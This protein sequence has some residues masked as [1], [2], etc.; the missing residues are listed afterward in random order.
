MIMEMCAGNAGR[1][2]F[3]R[4]NPLLNGEFAILSSEDAMLL[5]FANDSD[6]FSNFRFCKFYTLTDDMV[7]GKIV[8]QIQNSTDA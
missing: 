5:D 4:D 7:T 2:R 6:S 1:T 8:E 3:I